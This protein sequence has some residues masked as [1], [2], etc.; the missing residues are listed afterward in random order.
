MLWMK[1]CHCILTQSSRACVDLS[2]RNSLSCSIMKISWNRWANKRCV[3]SCREKSSWKSMKERKHMRCRSWRSST[4]RSHLSIKENRNDWS[5]CKTENLRIWTL[6]KSLET[7]ISKPYTEQK[8]KRNRN[9]NTWVSEQKILSRWTPREE[10]TTI[11]ITKQNLLLIISIRVFKKLN[12]FQLNMTVLYRITRQ[13]NFKVSLN[14]SKIPLMRQACWQTE[15]MIQTEF[16]HQL[17][18]GFQ[19]NLFA[20]QLK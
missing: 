2:F 18:K 9:R 3:S 19:T 4:S 1:R 14:R 15:T 8:T 11:W 7:V 5:K 16:H 20:S 13:L 17:L 10:A 6:M 12:P